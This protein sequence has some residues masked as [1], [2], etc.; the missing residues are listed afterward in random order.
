MAAPEV[1]RRLVDQF[2]RNYSTYKSNDYNETLLRQEFLN[3]FFEA[4]GWD[5]PF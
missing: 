1:I 5:R 3:P 2:R 4:L